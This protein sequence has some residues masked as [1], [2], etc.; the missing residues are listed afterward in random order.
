MGTKIQTQVIIMHTFNHIITLEKLTILKR[1]KNSSFQCLIRFSKLTVVCER[2]FVCCK[3][4][5]FS[6]FAFKLFWILIKVLYYYYFKYCVFDISFPPTGNTTRD[7]VHEYR[8]Q[9]VGQSFDRNIIKRK[10][11]ISFL[12]CCQSI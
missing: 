3:D 5:F 11:S 1:E 9:H 7:H 6:L 10:L 8:N 12:F 4:I 2:K